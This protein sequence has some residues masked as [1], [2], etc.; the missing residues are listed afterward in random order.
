MTSSNV[1]IAKE[2]EKAEL[3]PYQKNRI[4]NEQKGS[5]IKAKRQQDMDNKGNFD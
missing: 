4:C 1:N 2:Q 3:K 5:R